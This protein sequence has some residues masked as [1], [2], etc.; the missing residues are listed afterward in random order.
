MKTLIIFLI[1]ASFIQN[2]FLP[3]NLVLIILICR[4][5][6][7]PDRAN[8]FL[9]FSFGLLNSHLN[10]ITLGITSLVYL[11]IVAVVESLART[12]LAGSALIIAPLSF[13]LL[14]ADQVIVLYFAH[15]S[16]DFLKIFLESLISLPVFY[17]VKIWEE[18]FIV[19]KEIKLK[20][21]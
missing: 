18:R 1:I 20:V 7:R 6:L 8:L 11:T 16:L 3:F 13:G 19:R 14:F 15:Q 2:T 21:N 17:L 4:S 9:A 5:Y 10:L 12:R